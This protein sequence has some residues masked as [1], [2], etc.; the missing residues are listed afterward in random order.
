MSGFFEYEPGCLDAMPGIDDAPVAGIDKLTGRTYRLEHSLKLGMKEVFLN[1]RKRLLYPGIKLG[2]R[3][4]S[5]YPRS[6]VNEYHG[7]GVTLRLHSRQILGLKESGSGQETERSVEEFKCLGG[8]TAIARCKG[9]LGHGNGG[10]TL[11]KD[12]TT[13]TQGRTICSHLE[14]HVTVGIETVGLNKIYATLRSGQPTRLLTHVVVSIG[15]YEA[16]TT[17]KPN[18]LGCINEAPVTIEARVNSTMLTVKTVRQPKW[19]YVGRQFR[20]AESGICF[21]VFSD[22][23]RSGTLKSVAPLEETYRI[24]FGLHRYLFFLG[25]IL[26]RNSVL[27]QIKSDKLH[28]AL[29]GDDVSPIAANNIDYFL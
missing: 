4:S 14:I 9:I 18:G 17:L 22:L 5:T 6:C 16:E 26:E 7:D 10:E 15:G 28:Y 19:H 21:Q 23:H 8:I 25:H 3:N 24:E 29:A 2:N 13:L 20:F 11:G 27:P 1:T 12:V